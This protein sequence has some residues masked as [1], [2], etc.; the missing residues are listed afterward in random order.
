MSGTTWTILKA[1]LFF[2]A[3][4]P[5]LDSS[6]REYKRLGYSDQG[7]EDLEEISDL[8]GGMDAETANLIRPWYSMVEMGANGNKAVSLC[9]GISQLL[10][11]YDF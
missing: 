2:I 6:E 9:V 5:F 3:K 8:V 7:M 11:V 1:S 4:D 10:C